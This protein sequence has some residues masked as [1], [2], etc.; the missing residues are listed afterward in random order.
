MHTA[1]R[2][3]E[4]VSVR[5]TSVT[6][7]S[8]T[9][10]LLARG[11]SC[12]RGNIPKSWRPSN[13]DE[14]PH[15]AAI[16]AVQ[17]RASCTRAGQCRACNST[18]VLC[19]RNTVAALCAWRPRM[20]EMVNVEDTTAT[21]CNQLLHHHTHKPS[22]LDQKC[23]LSVPDGQCTA[24]VFLGGACAGAAHSW[25]RQEAAA[26]WRPGSQEQNCMCKG[27]CEAL[28]IHTPCTTRRALL[29]M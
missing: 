6:L 12:T 4:C 16:T 2:P 5:T 22:T 1:S 18:R 9:H 14:Q 8:P 15:K 17:D 7:C 24:A 20:A 27:C 28:H 3:Q 13:G 21:G 10:A 23:F 25:H 11:S 29:H 19:A 26:A